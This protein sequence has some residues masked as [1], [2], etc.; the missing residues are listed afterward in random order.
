MKN[1][2][3]A[4]AAAILLSAGIAFSFSSGN[5]CDPAACCDQSTQQ[6]LEASASNEACCDLP[7]P[8]PCCKD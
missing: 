8:I 4:I 7:C 2:S 1:K 6:T 5:C 3:L